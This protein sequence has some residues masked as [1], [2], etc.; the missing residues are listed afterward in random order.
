MVG[1][2]VYRTWRL[3]MSFSAFQFESWTISIHQFLMAK[4]DQGKVRLPM[5]GA[6]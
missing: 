5:S 1:E 4:L 2:P 3:Y 6:D